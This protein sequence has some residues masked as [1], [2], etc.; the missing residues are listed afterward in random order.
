MRQRKEGTYYDK[1]RES[2]LEYCRGR[3]DA[4][5]AN[6][7]RFREKACEE[8]LA[9]DHSRIQKLMWERAKSRAERDGVP[10]DIVPEDI[11]IPEYCPIFS[12]MRLVPG[13]DGYTK[14]CAPSLDKI[15]PELGYVKG[16]IWVISSF[17]NAMKNSATL[18]QLHIFAEKIK[19]LPQFQI[20]A[21][22]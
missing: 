18:E 22:R 10:F 20:N 17:A 16:N 15:I 5:K 12:N 2:I 7:R 3:K 11:I 6:K 1:N 8:F 21:G 4:M 19:L 13:N 14:N 9:G